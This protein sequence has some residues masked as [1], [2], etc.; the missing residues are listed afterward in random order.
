M[1]VHDRDYMRTD[2]SY[3]R[4]TQKPSILKRLLFWFHL[5]FRKKKKGDMTDEKS[6][7]EKRSH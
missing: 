7:K 5:V 6:E 2:R 3:K 4:S 1:S